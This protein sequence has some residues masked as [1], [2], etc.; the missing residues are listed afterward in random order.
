VTTT[1]TFPDPAAA[2]VIDYLALARM[3]RDL[4]L[5]LGVERHYPTELMKTR[6]G[7]HDLFALLVAEH[8]RA[9]QLESRLV[10]AEDALSRIFPGWE[11]GACLPDC[12]G[13]CCDMG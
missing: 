6:L 2:P 9:D 11:H 4:G 13:A 3:V 10:K 1:P 7:V 8:N 12:K 5:E